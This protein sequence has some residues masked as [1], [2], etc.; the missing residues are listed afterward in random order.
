M[1]AEKEKLITARMPA[2]LAREIDRIGRLEDLTRS[3]IIRDAV[4]RW[5]ES[6]QREAEAAAQAK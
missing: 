1:K 6:Y 4:R 2:K 3:Q 5:V